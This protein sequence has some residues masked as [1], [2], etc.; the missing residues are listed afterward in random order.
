MIQKKRKPIIV[1]VSNINDNQESQLTAAKSK[2]KTLDYT[3][4]GWGHAMHCFTEDKRYGSWLSRYFDKRRNWRRY[5]ALIHSSVTPNPNDVLTYKTEDGIRYA[6]VT[7]VR[8]CRDPED[9][10]EVWFVIKC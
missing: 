6:L 9:L 2:P 10:Y 4:Q 7:N 8:W 5:T 3:W 1:P